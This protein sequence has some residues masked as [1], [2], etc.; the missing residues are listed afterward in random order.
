[1]NIAT[2]NFKIVDD[3][4]RKFVEL[5]SCEVWTI[6][7]K[8]WKMN[9]LDSELKSMYTIYNNHNNQTLPPKFW[10]RLWILNK[11]FSLFLSTTCTQY[12]LIEQYMLIL[13]QL[14]YYWH[15]WVKVGDTPELHFNV[16][17]HYD[18]FFFF[19]ELE[20]YL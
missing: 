1:M 15:D 20:R 3:F 17:L 12:T 5:M 4:K 8:K 6:S 14:Q 9:K 7:I 18:T 16:C 2:N 11:Q 13:K 10:G 19:F